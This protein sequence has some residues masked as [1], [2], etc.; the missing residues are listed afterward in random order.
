MEQDVVGLLEHLSS[1]RHQDSNIFSIP[2]VTPRS[3]TVPSSFSLKDAFVLEV[4]EGI[5]PVRAFHIHVASL[6]PISAAWPAPRNELLT[7]E[8]DAPIAAVAC[9][10]KDSGT[11]YKHQKSKACL[12]GAQAHKNKKDP[13]WGPACVSP[14]LLSR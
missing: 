6:A 3:F 7:P 5:H 8:G 4:Q 10:N 9:V 14:E 13:I 12:E 2:S 1:G 11:I